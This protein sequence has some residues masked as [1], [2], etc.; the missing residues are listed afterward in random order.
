MALAARVAKLEAKHK[1]VL[2]C[3][4]CR[5]SL[6]DVPPPMQ[7][8][9]IVVPDSVLPTT[10][11][12]C[13]TKFVVPLPGLND[14]QREAVAL[15]YNSHPTKQFTDERVHA[16][17]I[18]LQLYHSEV[19]RYDKSQQE[20][21]NSDR[22]GQNRYSTSYNRTRG[23]LSSMEQKAKR[24]REELEQRA[25]EFHHAQT[26]RFKKL[27]NGPDTFPLDQAFAQIEKEYPTSGYDKT[28]DDFVQSL[29]FEKYSTATSRLRSALALCNV[30]LQN[31]KKREA[32]E[33]VLWGK[34][35]PETL[36]EI[37]VFEQI[38]QDEID[39]AL[40]SAHSPRL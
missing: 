21:A 34:L 5:F 32:C 28:I 14:R 20:Q 37:R 38:K 13:G 23:S 15:I 30:H 16:A 40:G 26:E 27:A 1:Q 33:I 12:F 8:S 35:L 25:F 11:R 17:P 6:R 31:L 22:S 39:N 10:C 29:G 24:D 7:K 3:F 36:E 18:W 19:T 9:N 2:R 4:W